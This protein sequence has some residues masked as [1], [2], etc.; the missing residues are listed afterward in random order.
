VTLEQALFH[1]RHEALLVQEVSPTAQGANAGREI[2]RRTDRAY[3]L[4][5]V[6]GVMT[7][8]TG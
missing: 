1:S 3:G 8:F 6:R 5:K 4:D 2:Y 7:E